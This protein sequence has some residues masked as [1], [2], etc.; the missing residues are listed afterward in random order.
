MLDLSL[1][2]DALR[3]VEVLAAL[4]ALVC[5]AEAL[6]AR[7]LLAEDGLLGWSVS[8]VHRRWTAHGWS[9][10]ALG[11]VLAYPQVLGLHALHAALAGV[12][13]V[14]AAPGGWRVAALAGIVGTS[15]LLVLRSPYGQDGADQMLLLAFVALL[16]ARAA[17]TP[18][19]QQAALWFLALQSALSYLTA[20]VAKAASPVWRDGSALPGIFGTR[21]YGDERVARAL[22][23]RPWLARW[24]ARGIV[25]FECAFPLVLALPP[26]L[27]A[28]ALLLG[29][30]FHATTAL[31]MGL[32][33][34]VWAF[35]ATYPAILHVA[36]ALHG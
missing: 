2:R 6:W 1:P 33:T 3:A 17:P 19:V 29:L 9:G 27:A 5:A 34:F 4:G 13:L 30:G 22:A 15:L 12:L 7:R 24:G 16:L 36:H 32:N 18:L 11:A 23:A 28:P 26:G 20:G 10:R 31:A 14:G 21:I 35:A 8:S 25:G